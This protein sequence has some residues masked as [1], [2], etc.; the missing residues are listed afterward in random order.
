MPFV[1]NAGAPTHATYNLNRHLC[2]M[3]SRPFSC[4]EPNASKLPF[5]F[6]DSAY[7]LKNWRL[8]SMYVGIET[9]DHDARAAAKSY[10]KQ[11][12]ISVAFQLSDLLVL[13]DESG[14]VVSCSKH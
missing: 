13:R 14:P 7:E 10:D 2:Q 5:A 1:P 12:D 6:P 9:E 11:G 3:I 4:R 8:T